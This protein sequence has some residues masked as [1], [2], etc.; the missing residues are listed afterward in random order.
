MEKFTV[1]CYNHFVL[2]K[3]LDCLL[4]CRNKPPVD[5]S[6][7]TSIDQGNRSGKGGIEEAIVDKVKVSFS[8]RLYLLSKFRV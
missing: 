8:N 1:A 6:K 5:R 4:E 2:W 7:R 3:V